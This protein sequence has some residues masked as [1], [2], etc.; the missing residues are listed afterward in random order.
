MFMADGTK[1]DNGLELAR[2]LERLRTIL[3]ETG[4]VCES[5]SSEEVL[6]ILRVCP[7]L[8]ISDWHSLSENH[9]LADWLAMPISGDLFPE[10]Q[11]LQER[12]ARLAHLSEHDPLTGLANRRAFERVLDIEVERCRRNRTPV[13]LVVLD[14][15]DFKR[16]ND[17]YGH[18]FGDKVLV[19][20][21][22][23]LLE[24]KRRY[25]LA[26]RTGGEEFSLVLTGIGLIRAQT[27]VDR[28]LKAVRELQLD[29]DGEPI[30]LTCSAGIASYKGRVALTPVELVELADKALYE[31]KHSG[32]NRHVSA[33]IPDMAAPLPEKSLVHSNEKKFL[34]T[35]I[36]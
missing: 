2:E 8:P 19:A 32:K 29:C 6:A 24:E 34:F 30:R 4:G 28:V 22:N 20:V 23:V 26:A 16:V 5:R 15:D 27:M 14:L 33:A 7:G 35:G 25:D 21:A 12:L 1:I 31:A 13:S 18:P 17:T 11:R 10:L 3:S 9:N 36:K